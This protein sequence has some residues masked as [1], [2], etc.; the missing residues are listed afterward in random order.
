M[1]E[2]HRALCAFAASVDR[3]CLD[4]ELANVGQIFRISVNLY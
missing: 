4:V 1:L 2:T 3:P